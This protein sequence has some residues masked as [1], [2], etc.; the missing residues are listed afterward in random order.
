MQFKQHYSGS[1]GNLY[2]V[3]ANNGKRL[4]IEC[5]VTWPKIQ[6]ALNYD[7]KHIVACFVT[8][9]HKD[10][11]KALKDVRLAGIEIY[12]SA[13]TFKSFNMNC[14]FSATSNI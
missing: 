1:S 7:L 10:H 3:I 14:I 5:G 11:S 13:E 12:A 8:H 9:G 2:E 6:K 4:L